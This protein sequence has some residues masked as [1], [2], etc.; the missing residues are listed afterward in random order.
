MIRIRCPKCQAILPVEEALAGTIV[1]CPQCAAKLR[2]P[3]RSPAV[4]AAEPTLP[5]P[6]SEPARVLLVPQPPPLPR[7]DAEEPI[8]LEVAREP[9]SPE[10][11]AVL[12][13][14][15]R[16]QNQS[17]GWGG[18]IAILV[19]S[20]VLFTGAA[21]ADETWAG[22]AVLVPV[23]LFHELGHYVAMRCFGYRNLRMFFIPF[24]GAAVS[25]QNYNVAGWKKAVVALA[26]PVPGIVLGVPLGVA[27]L[28][29]PQSPLSRAAE[30]LLV[31]NAFNLLP[32][33]PLDGGWVVHAVLFVRHPVLDV[34]FRVVAALGLLG[35]GTLLGSWVLAGLSV[36]ML[37]AVPL[38]WRLAG[39]AHRLRREGLVA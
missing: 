14:L 21:R 24:F 1:P 3:A 15:D 36:L 18:A 37:L 16:L 9:I 26:G 27:A 6:E 13:E 17:A 28:F 19:I 33:L 10:D 20:L 4:V 35:L 23:L 12:A 38:A 7:D 34:L 32:F 11:E 22:L 8:E 31:I 5:P 25:G 29:V 39:I 30:I 2:V